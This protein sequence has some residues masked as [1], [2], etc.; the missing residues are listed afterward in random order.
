MHLKKTNELPPLTAPAAGGNI[1]NIG[2]KEQASKENKE[3]NNK[4]SGNGNKESKNNEKD[5]KES[6]LFRPV[7]E[8]PDASPQRMRTRNKAAKEQTTSRVRPK[9]G[10][11]G[12]PEPKTPSKNNFNNNTS[13]KGSSN[14][15]TTPVKNGKKA[16]AEK[17][18]T[19]QK[20]R[21]RGQEKIEESETDDK[22]TAIFKKKRE[23][24]EVCYVCSNLKNNNFLFYR[25]RVLPVLQPI[26]DL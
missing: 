1:P 25:C 18:E 16:K 19:T 22:E 7:A 23:R 10:E 4:E 8:S 26:L 12:T 11:S 17:A 9:R 2:I 13:E 14:S 24:A 15:S 6:Y 20:N 3:T 5:N 21:K